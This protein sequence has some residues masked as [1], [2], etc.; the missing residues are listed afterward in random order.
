MQETHTPTSGEGA[1]LSRR[2]F[3][4]I[5]A[6]GTAATLP[7]V[8]LAGAN[9]K[10]SRLPQPFQDPEFDPLLRA[11]Q[12]YRDANAL[13]ER[14]P[15]CADI[16]HAALVEATYGPP[17]EVLKDWEQPAVSKA[18]AIE[19]LKLVLEEEGQFG[20]EVTAR[21]VAS[22]LTWLDPSS[23]ETDLDEKSPTEAQL[24]TCINNLRGIL[25]DMNKP[26][27]VFA[28]FSWSVD[29]SEDVYMF[30]IKYP[31]SQWGKP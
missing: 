10:T 18:G 5:A 7:A 8:A 21:M 19:A 20:S 11:I 14:N 30:R 26:A 29:R 25:A 9:G 22:V 28:E 6:A 16:D 23:A 31:R 3:I 17:L 4:A 24:T 2:N 27:E 12:R 15:G 1:S 13:F